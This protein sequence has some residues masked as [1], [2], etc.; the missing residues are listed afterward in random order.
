[1]STKVNTAEGKEQ[2]LESSLPQLYYPQTVIYEEERVNMKDF[3]IGALVGGIVGAAAGLLLA[4]KSGKDL[5]S[6]VA[7]QAVHLKDRSAGFST[8]AKDKTL[9]LSKQIQEQ[10]TQLVEK[11]K[12]IK[13][14]KAP[15]V[16]DDGTVSFEGE[17]PLEEFVPTEEE[18]VDV[19]NAETTEETRA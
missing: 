18:Q 14:A 3:V 19:V 7:V 4:P 12:T 13:T 16:F 9:Q 11:V 5:R 15:T 10:S 2:Q 17:E 1:M 6:D 8:T